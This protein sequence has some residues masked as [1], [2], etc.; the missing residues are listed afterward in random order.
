MKVKAKLALV[1]NSRKF[2]VRLTVNGSDAAGNRS[3]A[4]ARTIKVRG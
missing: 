4:V 3:A 1:K 2:T